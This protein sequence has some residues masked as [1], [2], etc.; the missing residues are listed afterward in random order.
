MLHNCDTKDSSVVKEEPVL[1][2]EPLGLNQQITYPYG[3]VIGR[4]TLTKYSMEGQYVL[5][6]AGNKPR[7]VSL[8][9]FTLN[10]TLLSLNKGKEI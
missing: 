7:V 6:P 5:L 2:L 8:T 9:L 10:F 1:I 3:I 4:Y